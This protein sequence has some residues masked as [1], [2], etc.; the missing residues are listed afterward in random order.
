MA[1]LGGRPFVLLWCATLF[2]Y[3]SFQLLLAVL[4]LY[5]TRLGGR[6]AHVGL[7]IGLFAFSAMLLRPIA[8]QL[9][10]SVG[11]RPLVL[12]GAAIFALAALGYPLAG[13]ITGLLVLRLFHGVGMGLMPTAGTV[14][15]TD[16]APAEHRGAALGAY[17]LTTSIGLAVAPFLGVELSRRAGFTATFLT[18]AAL[19]T[20]AVGLAWVLP[21]T[22]PPAGAP[23]SLLRPLGAE[24]AT[25]AGWMTRLFSRGAVYPSLLLLALFVSYGGVMSFVPLFAERHQLG[26]PGLFFTLFALA[27]V[28]VRS[29]AGHVTDRIGRRLVIA[30]AL[31]LAG[32]ALAGL[33]FATSVRGLAGAAVLYGVGFGAALPALMAMTADRVPVEERGRAMG[34]LYTAWELGISGGSLLLGLCAARFGYSIM[35][36]LAAGITGAGALGATRQITRLRG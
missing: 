16:L 26:N 17:G 27:A 28:V 33:G 7:I 24:A 36:W 14:M 10:D 11:R 34:T 21:E 29:R 32:L 1:R 31:A 2:F 4:P 3:L 5:A 12:A 19:A 22:R 15:V 20:A 8:G 35:W 13:G 6:E 25:A 18:A 23:A 9:A 30:P